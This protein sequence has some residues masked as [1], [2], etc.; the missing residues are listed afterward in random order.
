M[1]KRTKIVATISGNNCDAAFM[2]ELVAKGVNVFRINTAHQ[3]LEEAA[4]VLQLIRE[5]APH[6]AVLI[7]TKGPEVRTSSYG[8]A[9]EVRKGDTIKIEGNPNGESSREVVYVN[10]VNFVDDVSV[11]NRVLIDD[12]ETGM[13]VIDKTGDTLICKVENDGVIKL[14]K[15]V[16]VPSVELHLPVISEKDRAF[17]QFAIDHQLDFIAHSFVQHASDVYTIKEILDAQQSEVKIIAKI[18]NQTGVDNIDEIIEAADGIMV[19]RGDMGI[20]IPIERIPVIQRS[21]VKACIRAN[22]PVIIATQMLHSMIHN[23]RPTRAEVTDIATAV[24]EKADALMLS[25]ETAMGAY[26][27]ESVEMMAKVI[28]ETENLLSESTLKPELNNQNI[29]SVL[30]HSA[31]LACTNLPIKA[32]IVDTLTGRTPKFLSSYRGNVPVYAFCYSDTV[33]RQLALSYGVEAYAIEQENSRDVFIHT[34]VNLLLEKDKLKLDD[35]VVVL[36]GSFGPNNGATF[37]EISTVKN[38]QEL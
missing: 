19:A 20:E 30:S 8:E 14:R 13:F 11:G 4:T 35:L 23:P 12:G 15:G 5:T 32:I 31:V 27:L 17:I 18:E 6:A 9:V 22:K 2:K 29:L 21:M 1:K 33:R 36:G 26:K 34:T 7:D 25:G 28:K 16:N 3:A 24:Y 10:A 37:V 38:L